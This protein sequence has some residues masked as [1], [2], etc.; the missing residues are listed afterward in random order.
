MGAFPV[1]KTGAVIQVPSSRTERFATSIIQFI[2]G[3]EQR[4]RAFPLPYHSWNITF[5][6]LDDT[7]IHN[8]RLFFQQMN[9]A[10]GV[11][12][13]TDPWDGTVYT[14]CSFEASDLSEVATGPQRSGT[15]LTIRENRQ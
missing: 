4:F 11:F 10:A 9:G 5:D 1:L 7:E 2:D 6:Y 13:F 15:K 8:I 12:T 14:K 3:S